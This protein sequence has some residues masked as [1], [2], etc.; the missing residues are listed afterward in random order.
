MW[1]MIPIF[2]VL[3]RENSLGTEISL[4]GRNPPLKGNFLQEIELR[5]KKVTLSILSVFLPSIVSEGFVSFRHTMSVLSPLYGCPF[6]SSG[7]H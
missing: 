5:V 3:S 1:A 7:F 2:L 6:P 4:W